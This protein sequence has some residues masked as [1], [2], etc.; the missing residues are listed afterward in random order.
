MFSVTPILAYCARIQLFGTF[1]NSAYPSKKH[2]IVFS[3]FVFASSLFILY[4]LYDSLDKVLGIIGASSGFILIYLIPS[5]IN[6][7]YYK[8]KHQDSI[9]RYNSINTV[10]NRESIATKES[11][12]I[13]TT[14]HS[15]IKKQIGQSEKPYNNFKNW[16]FYISQILLIFLG[17]FVLISQ[18]VDIKFYT[19]HIN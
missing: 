4:F 18:F 11:T 1:F 16:I 15:E 7:V 8:L 2:I 5:G 6:I 17:L 9:D 10:V 12:E 13:L 14:E 3:L 19:I